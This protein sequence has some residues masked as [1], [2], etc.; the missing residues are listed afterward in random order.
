MDPTGLTLVYGNAQLRRALVFEAVVAN[1]GSRPIGG[2]DSASRWRIVLNHP[3]RLRLV[4]LSEVQR[5]PERIGDSV[6]VRPANNGIEI[7]LGLLNP[8]DEIRIGLIALEHPNE[9]RIPLTATSSPVP[10]LE[11]IAV[12]RGSARK[13]IHSRIMDRIVAPIWIMAFVSLLIGWVWEERRNKKALL[14]KVVVPAIV[15]LVLTSGF[16]A[17][18]LSWG[19]G[20]LGV[21]AVEAA[22]QGM[23]GG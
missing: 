7:T 19:L 14:I 21:L 18:V 22:G 20:W 17:Y 5:D 13:G 12:E 8:N 6:V 16:V 3:D 9:F 23:G 11:R 1:T 2:M 10:G 15:L 4:Q